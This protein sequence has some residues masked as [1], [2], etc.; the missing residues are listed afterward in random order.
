MRPIDIPTSVGPL[1][2]RWFGPASGTQSVILLHEGLGSVSTWGTFP[3][4]L[5]ERLQ[6][7]VLAFSRRGYGQSSPRPAPWPPEYMHQEAP[8]LEEVLAATTS[9]PVLLVGHSDGASIATVYA[10]LEPR[11]D[12]V[13]RVR[14]LVLIAP[15][16]F[17]EEMSVRAIETAADRYRDGTLR[18]RLA[19][20]HRDVDNAFWGWNGAW[21]SAAFRSWDIRDHLARVAV[22]VLVAQGTSD[23]Y[24]S[25]AHVESV[26]QTLPNATTEPFPGVGHIPHKEVPEALCETIQRFDCAL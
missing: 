21:R 9:G 15:H 18:E 26:E 24:G 22:P 23:P 8:L 7:P 3:E 2:G 19:R 11:S 25:W 1:E 10:G 16:F 4:R 12:S 20:H 6:Q 5:A 14:G 17:V 13:E